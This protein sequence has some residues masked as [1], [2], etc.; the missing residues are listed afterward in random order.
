M[1]PDPVAEVHV[2]DRSTLRWG[3]HK[4][5]PAPAGQQHRPPLQHVGGTGTTRCDLRWGP[6]LVIVSWVTCHCPPAVAARGQ[7]GGA[8][9]Q[10]VYCN[11]EPGCQ[12]VWYRP[13]H[14]PG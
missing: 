6:G 14:E 5:I 8:G 9:H 13:P 1:P 3:E 11:A 2:T 7:Y 10:A 12:S 4:L